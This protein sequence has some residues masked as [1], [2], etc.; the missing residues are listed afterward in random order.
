MSNAALDIL[1]DVRTIKA[2]YVHHAILK[3]CVKS[4]IAQSHYLQTLVAEFH[5]LGGLFG[6]GIARGFNELAPYHR[7]FEKFD[8]SSKGPQLKRTCK[9]C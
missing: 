6:A 8:P 7:K 2:R 5:I 9:V 1:V 4:V 3:G